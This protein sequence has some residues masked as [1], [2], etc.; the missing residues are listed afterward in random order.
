MAIGVSK[1]QG[2]G[3]KRSIDRDLERIVA[4]VRL[5]LEEIETAE[6]QKR[7]ERVGVGATGNVEMIESDASNR[8]ATRG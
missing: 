6:P 1:T 3:S 7:P 8:D 4:R 2:N 5:V